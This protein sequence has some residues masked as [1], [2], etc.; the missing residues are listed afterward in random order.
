MGDKKDKKNKD[1]K[2][3]TETTNKEDAANNNT[4]DSYDKNEM[5]KWMT[6]PF[7]PEDNPNG[8]TEESSFA[9][10]FPQYREAYLKEVWPVVEERLKPHG[11]IASLDLIK[12]CMTVKTTRK[13][14][15]PYI[16]VKARDM[17][18]LLSRSVPV[19]QAAK[20]LDDRMFCDIIKIKNLVANKQKYVKRRQRLLGPNNSTLKAI[21]L[22]TGC[23]VLVQG[24]TVSCMGPHK[25]ILLVRKVV[26]DCMKNVHPIYHIKSLMIKR[27]LTKKEE[28]K[29]ENWERFL[30]KF[31]KQNPKKKK[32]AEKEQE[33]VEKIKAKKEKEYT[34]FPPQQQ[35]R[36]EDLQL[37]SGEYFLN[38]KEQEQIKEAERKE[39]KKLKQ[40]KKKE[41][42]AKVFV[43][44]TEKIGKKSK[45]KQKD[46]SIDEL[47]TSIAEKTKK[48]KREDGAK[49][50]ADVSD[51][52][53]SKKSKKV[54]T[55]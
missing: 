5:N 2:E 39:K 9:T 45:S 1:K 22:V 50:N 53:E 18:K 52:V 51:F 37:A 40:E 15:D 36:K 12:G 24:N 38:K 43:P 3:K 44:P 10:L 13:T 17:I 26:E 25:G 21:E 27:E 28:F 19:Q 55:K 35:P 16:I 34:P 31:K 23:Y 4:N 11:I 42:K 54:K 30:P 29:N 20:I 48:R 8:L 47:K 7:T 33:K 46:A 6:L 49:G 14:Y 41:E 32:N